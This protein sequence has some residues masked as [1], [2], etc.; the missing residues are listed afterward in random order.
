M[1]LDMAPGEALL[2]ERFAR[3]LAAKDAG[4][5]GAI[6]G[7]SVDFRGMTPGRFWRASAPH[8]VLDVLLG[9]WFEPEDHIVELCSVSEG[10]VADREH[11]AYRLRVRSGDR[12]FLVEQQAYFMAEA[13]RITWMRVLCSGFRPDVP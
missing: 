5:L 9:H 4:T 12:P 13:G 11:V 2:G 1:A 10:R 8:E 3:A 7:D 6:L